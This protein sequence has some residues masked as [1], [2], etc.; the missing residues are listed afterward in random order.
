MRRRARSLTSVAVL[1]LLVAACG[2]Q[3]STTDPTGTTAFSSPTTGVSTAP[4]PNPGSGET[5]ATLTL[6]DTTYQFRALGDNDFCDPEH[7]GFV[8]R[9]RLAGVDDNGQPSVGADTGFPMRFEALLGEGTGDDG[10]DE[11]T[12]T[13]H[14]GS[15]EVWLA[16]PT[17]R[18]GTE[19]E[20][21][22]DRNRASGTGTFLESGS[23]EPVSGSFEVFCAVD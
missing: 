19:V 11:A 4:L 21:T 2:S 22:I 14:P 20:F 23:D 18:E 13:F 17:L 7:L 12:V 1:G 8:F 5:A 6:G 15:G 16:S 9:A 3:G 10:S